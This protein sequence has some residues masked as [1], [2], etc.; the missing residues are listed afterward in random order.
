MQEIK[1]RY[2]SEL[3]DLSWDLEQFAR[4]IQQRVEKSKIDGQ[5]IIVPDVVIYQ[6]S[7]NA[8]NHYVIQGR[9]KIGRG[10]IQFTQYDALLRSAGVVTIPNE[11]P[12]GQTQ[13]LFLKELQNAVDKNQATKRTIPAHEI[14]NYNGA[15]LKE[16]GQIDEYS[17]AHPSLP[18]GVQLVIGMSA[19]EN[20]TTYANN[21]N[22]IPSV[23]YIRLRFTEQAAK[24]A[25]QLGFTKEKTD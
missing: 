16:G 18:D 23:S 14:H 1:W 21:S 11:Y 13:T 6:N 19:R 15:T 17:F 3:R 7:E 20:G 8:A 22:A 2:S 25:S 10:N 24:D 9:D 5:E 12:K 4:T